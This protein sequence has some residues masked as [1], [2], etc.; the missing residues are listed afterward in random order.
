MVAGKEN[1]LGNIENDS[2]NNDQ[3]MGSSP[4]ENASESDSS[5][6]TN[7][8][9]IGTLRLD[10]PP[11]SKSTQ[12]KKSL[13]Y[14]NSDD[15]EEEE[16]GQ[17][18]YKEAKQLR[19]EVNN[20]VVSKGRQQPSDEV[21]TSV[22]GGVRPWEFG[23][24]IQ[25]EYR[26]RLP[27]NYELKYWK[28][29]SKIM[30]ESIFRLLET[31]TISVLDSVF[32]KYE[33][34]LKQMTHGDDNELKRIYSK[35][36][37]LLETIVSKINKKLR[38]AKFP[39]RISE[40]D[41]DIEYIYSKRQFIQNRYAQELQNCER[42]E[43]NLAREQK[44]LEETR[45][46]CRNLKTSNKRRLTEKLIQ[47]DL[48]P[49]LNKALEYTYGLESSNGFTQAE[50]QVTFKNDI[51]ELNLLLNRPIKSTTDISLDKRE[52]LSLL[53]S[54]QEYA[55]T[56]RELKGTMHEIVSDSHEQEIKEV[57]DHRQRNHQSET[58]EDI[59]ERRS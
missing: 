17:H 14:E 47:R 3:T 46:L 37:R 42:L 43:T 59:R 54:L 15:A 22:E 25:A 8:N 39:S 31:N 13:F 58:E 5:I 57:I 19:F 10:M 34:E 24:V 21:T 9:D 38:Q 2:M 7:V 32:E 56:S 41:L 27:H 1:F 51:T 26:E 11:E 23:K 44:L 50:G 6:L 36:E 33:A 16:D 4:D 18:R 30:L 20:G 35:K 52:V 53:P 48:H 45:K 12:S 40:R 28:K 49:A 55:N 29:P